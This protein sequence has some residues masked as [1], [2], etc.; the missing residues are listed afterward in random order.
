MR[1]MLNERR[2]KFQ[3][4]TARRRPTNVSLSAELVEEA[5]TLG[6]NVSKACEEGLAAAN[7]KE[8][9]K[10]WLEENA[11]AIKSHNEWVAKNGLPLAKYRMF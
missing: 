3:G 1:M 10:R 6:I 9:E 8:R 5:K 4:Q 11:E 2:E 7:K